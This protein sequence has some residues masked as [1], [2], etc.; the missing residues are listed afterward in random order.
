MRYLLILSFVTLCNVT[1]F[2]QKKLAVYKTFGGVVYELDSIAVSTKQ[3]KMILQQNPHAYKEFRLAKT[4]STVD[5]LLGFSGGLL[6]GF[7]IGEAIAGVKPEWG[8]AAVGAVLLGVSIP[9]NISFKNR[10][11]SA[12]DIYNE[13]TPTSRIQPSFHF[14]GSGANLTIKF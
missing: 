4:N 10:A 11:V 13:T 2:A 14:T 9:F 1:S 8:F 7:P 12:I 5:T 3:V 6:V